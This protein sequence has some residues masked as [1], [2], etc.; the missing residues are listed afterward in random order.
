MDGDNFVSFQLAGRGSETSDFA[1]FNSLPDA[2]DSKSIT[3]ANHKA[4]IAFFFFNL[5]CL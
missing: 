5:Q 4:I 1:V 3:S 2:S